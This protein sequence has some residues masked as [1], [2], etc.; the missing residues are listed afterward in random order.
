MTLLPP[1]AREFS[2]WFSQFERACFR[3]E[4][5][6]S[7]G[8]SGEDASFAAYLAGQYPPPDAERQDWTRLVRTATS[9]GRIMSRVHVVTE[10]LSDYL[11]FELA[12]S[13]PQ[14]VAAG[15]DVRILLA[16]GDEW[17]ADVPRSD[18]WL[19]DD[20]ELFN[21]AYA[22]DGT[23]LGAEHVTNPAAVTRACRARDVAWRLAQPWA[24][25]IQERPEL[26]VSV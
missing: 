2:S 20:R 11:R 4:T 26:R 17:P 5:L 15:E 9:H 8:G 13:Y 19:F 10:P 1:Y 22:P 7:Y 16:T 18:F 24:E 6:A 14:S 21:M 12:W 3:L 25:F 23:W